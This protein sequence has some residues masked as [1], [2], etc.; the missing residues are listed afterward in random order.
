MLSGVLLK[1]GKL[2]DE[3]WEVMKTHTE[4][5]Y[6][7]ANASKELKPIAEYILHH[8]ERWDGQGYPGGLSGEEIPILSRII[9]VVD[10]HDVMV[11]DR[12]Y[13]KAM[14]HAEAV[15]ELLRC[16]GSQFDPHIV[17][18]FLQVLQEEK[19]TQIRRNSE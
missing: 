6:R 9:T 2:T 12:P 10:S 7:I 3:E 13:H 15:E 8:H 4:K 16:S 1:P 19:E 11:H 14:S 5:G 17:T 18:I